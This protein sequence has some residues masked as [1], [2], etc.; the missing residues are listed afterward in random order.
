MPGALAY[1]DRIIKESGVAAVASTACGFSWPNISIN[2]PGCLNMVFNDGFRVIQSDKA[3]QDVVN[4]DAAYSGLPM[5]YQTGFVDTA[6]IKIA[7][8]VTGNFFMS[9]IPDVY[10]AIVFTS[11]TDKFA[12]SLRP[13]A[14][15][16]H[17]SH[18]GGAAAMS[19]KERNEEY[20][21][22]LKFFREENIP[23]HNDL[24]MLQDGTVVRSIQAM[25]YESYL[26]ARP[27]H[28]HKDIKTSHE[29]QLFLILRDAPPHFSQMIDDWSR[30]F[31]DQHQ[32]D[33]NS[34]K[35]QLNSIHTKFYL[36]LRRLK[37]YWHYLRYM[38]AIPSEPSLPIQTVFDA[39]LV[40]AT[41][42]KIKPSWAFRISHIAH[43][44][45]QR[46]L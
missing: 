3:L 12:S 41:L 34:V 29:K 37:G 45:R 15:C 5:M 6:L 35:A 16:G 38:I 14:I 23:F 44:A 4:G 19:N 25:V 7:K 30:I 2:Q 39:G 28:H 22:A 40:A 9:M 42:L 10:S 32:L 11:L 17:S 20:N 13:L 31:A 18:S 21:P 1:V 36:L 8:E 46:F 27:F 43:K 24:P 26:Q 33:L